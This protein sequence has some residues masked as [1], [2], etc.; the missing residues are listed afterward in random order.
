MW[1]EFLRTLLAFL[2]VA[3]VLV[4]VA[5]GIDFFATWVSGFGLPVKTTFFLFGLAAGAY[6]KDI[7]NL[8]GR[9]AELVWEKILKLM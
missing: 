8:I 1:R 3:S 5:T 2:V 7:G 4:A 9:F 6:A